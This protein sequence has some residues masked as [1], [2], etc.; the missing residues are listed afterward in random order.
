ML[1]SSETRPAIDEVIA[2]ALAD[3]D[4][5]ALHH[6]G[7]A[8]HGGWSLF[9]TWDQARSGSVPGAKVS[10]MRA[11]RRVACGGEVEHL[12]E[13]GHLLLDDLG[14]AVLDRLGGGAR[15]DRRDGDRRRRNRRVLGNRELKDRSDT[16]DHQNDGNDPGEDRAL[17]EETR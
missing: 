7:Q 6:F 15:I 12:V 1:P 3:R 9:C 10:S 17:K 4:T 2:G 16:T 14:D 13:P 8:R 11:R 5:L